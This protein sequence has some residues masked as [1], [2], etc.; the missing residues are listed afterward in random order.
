MSDKLDV[1]FTATESEHSNCICTCCHATD[2]VLKLN[3][4]NTL[5]Y[6]GKTLSTTYFGFWLC[7]TCREKLINAILGQPLKDMNSESYHEGSNFALF[8]VAS[9][10]HIDSK[11]SKAALCA[12][13]DLL[14]ARIIDSL[15]TALPPQGDRHE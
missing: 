5:Y 12:K 15:S 1:K 10:L 7:Q 14:A 2:K 8:E 13:A 6:D 9:K 4:P 3:I 11:L